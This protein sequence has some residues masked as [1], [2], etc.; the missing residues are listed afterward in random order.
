MERLFAAALALG[1]LAVG[2][3]PSPTASDAGT[4]T[5]EAAVVASASIADAMPTVDAAA[6]SYVHTWPAK[7][8]DS[9]ELLG[10]E[11]AK[12]IAFLRL[13]RERR[14]PERIVAVDLEAKQA[15][16]VLD[17]KALPRVLQIET[18]TDDGRVKANA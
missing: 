7:Y 14:G 4:G 12:K 1:G 6:S 8:P 15:S 3:R 18:M 2:C 11:R 16:T 5:V 10:I 17:L 9:V 13:S